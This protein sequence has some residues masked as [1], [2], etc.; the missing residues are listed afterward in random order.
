[1]TRPI[2]IRLAASLVSAAIVG[3]LASLGVLLLFSTQMKH[4]YDDTL[5][6]GGV[7]LVIAELERTPRDQWP[8]VLDDVRAHISHRLSIEPVGTETQEFTVTIP[9]GDS[10]QALI[11]ESSV[12]HSLLPILGP[13]LAFAVT[14]VL[15]GAGFVAWPMVAEI[16]RLRLAIR[17]LGEGRLDDRTDAH[18]AGALQGLTEELNRS[19]AQLARMFAERESLMQAVCH[20]LGVPLSRMRFTL[21]M[22][23]PHVTPQ[24]HARIEA[25]ERDLDELDEMNAELVSWVEA[26]AKEPTSTPLELEPVLEIL[27]ELT[28]Y[29]TDRIDPV[30]D[31]PDGLE[32]FAEERQFQRAIENLLRNATRYAA[33]T[34][35][36]AA[37]REGSQVIVEVRDDG[38]GIPPDQRE[39][40]FE[41][42]TRVDPSRSREDGG[43]GLGLAIVHRIVTAHGGDVR[44]DD[45]PEGGASLVTSWPAARPTA[46]PTTGPAAEPTAPDSSAMSP[47]GGSKPEQQTSKT[48]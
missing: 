48:Q 10:G 46:R 27:V 39:H 24:Q 3:I 25:L 42:F 43:L 19:A 6:G 40:L 17:Q 14:I 34:V 29:E 45:A 5:R 11:M 22:L 47:A 44:I 7:G 1:M 37:R 18:E 20:E 41:P 2:Y 32:V 28:C 15:V 35:V 12:N 36:L 38:P 8:E 31:V 21:E 9:I 30:V 4:E 23:S 13:M 16:S 26:G 33:S